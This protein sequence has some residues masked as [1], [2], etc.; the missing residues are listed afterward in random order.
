MRTMHPSLS[1]DLNLPAPLEP[2]ERMP[3][4]EPCWCG[5]GKKWKR[6]HRDRDKQ[7][8]IIVGKMMADHQA[9]MWKGYCLHPQA[10]STNCSQTIIRAH[11]VQRR[12]GLAAIAEHGHVMSP[13]RGLNDIFKNDGEIVPRLQGIN[14]ASTFMGF[15]RLHD[16][17][18]FAPIEKAPL[19]LCKE[20][21]CLLS[22]R[23]IC[24]ERHMKTAALRAIEI[25]RDSDK[26]DSFEVQCEKQNYLHYMREGFRRG[27][28]DF[29]G[30]KKSYDTA[31][32]SGNYDNFSFFGVT[33][34]EALPIVA[35]GAFHP[36]FDFTGRSLQIITRGNHTFDHISFNLTIVNGK[37]VAVFGW[38][39]S[40]QGPAEQFIESFRAL[41]RN[42][43]ANAVFHI[44]CE[45]LENTY[46]R[47]SW[48]DVRADSAKEYLIK[49]FRSGLPSMERP[50]DCL[51]RLDHCFST[52][53][54]EFELCSN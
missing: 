23:A 33:F 32:L 8:P 2:R 34:S 39:G 30:W 40:S 18:L 24:Y 36:G 25:Q 41:P 1:S 35:C 17:Q 29:E 50:R 44:A 16:D 45:Y 14:D 7:Q 47:P 26:G 5:S 42:T 6:C 15:C 19:V 43:M 10:S 27:L 54:V 53:S 21:A 20:S 22:F 13:K 4:N 28:A 31:L 51:S 52:S 49:R 12:G 11:T 48:W 37:S 46:L 9:E 38:T 3:V